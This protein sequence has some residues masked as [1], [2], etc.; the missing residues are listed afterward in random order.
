MCVCVREIEGERAGWREGARE[1]Q[2]AVTSEFPASRERSR[3]LVTWLVTKTGHEH[4][5]RDWSRGQPGHE[6]S[7]ASLSRLLPGICS[8]LGRR[9]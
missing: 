6:G 8:S 9:L 3:G 1:C 5:S 7:M 4:W 2:S